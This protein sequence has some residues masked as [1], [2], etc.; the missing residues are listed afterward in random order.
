MEVRYP[1]PMGLDTVSSERLDLPLLS[2]GH[3]EAL[4]DG[5]VNEVGRAIGASISPS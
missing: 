4:L 1:P 5:K 3:M 2:A